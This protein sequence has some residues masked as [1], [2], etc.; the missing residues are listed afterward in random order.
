MLALL[1]GG[2]TTAPQLVK[3]TGYPRSTVHHAVNALRAS[4]D[5]EVSNSSDDEERSGHATLRVSAILTTAT[6]VGLSVVDKSGAKYLVAV[7]T[8]RS[9]NDTVLA[10]EGS[11][12][13]D[14]QSPEGLVIAVSEQVRRLT[15]AAPTAA[16]VAA[17]G[18]SVPAYVDHEAGTVAFSGRF[19][20]E[21]QGAPIRSLLEERIGLPVVLEMNVDAFALKEIAAHAGSDLTDSFLLIL[22]G[23]GLGASTVI[24]GG[25]LRGH[26][27]RAGELGHMKVAGLTDLCT[28]GARGCLEEVA[29]YRSIRRLTGRRSIVRIVEDSNRGDEESSIVLRAAARELA[30]G[31]GA[32]VNSTDPGRLI[33][34][35]GDLVASFEFQRAFRQELEDYV[36]P[37]QQLP[38]TI[39]WRGTDHN[40]AVRGA[41]WAAISRFPRLKT[42]RA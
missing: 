3:L 10:P 16:P 9:P 21:Q 42:L 23:E 22:Q 35:V 11:I 40:D 27:G 1:A 39:Q 30:R 4:G 14:D 28:C 15:E 5:V 6:F 32:F 12:E 31:V 34:E 18:L 13:L 25:I 26:S 2:P 20:W 33:M 8:T 37:S 7:R 19:G 38:N 29:T 17:V 41:A 36:F 24:E